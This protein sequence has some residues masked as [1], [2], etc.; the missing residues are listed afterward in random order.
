ML[1]ALQH[2]R[3]ALPIVRAF[4]MFLKAAMRNTCIVPHEYRSRNTS[5]MGAEGL[6]QKELVV[7]GDLDPAAILHHLDINNVTTIAPVH[8]GED[9]AIWR[10]EHGGATH[11]LRV[12]R[13]EQARAF[14]REVAALSA[15]AAAGLPVPAVAA[16]GEWHERPVM[17]LS[18]CAGQ[19]LLAALRER[20]WQVA[21]LGRLFGQTHARIHRITAPPA[22]AQ[23]ATA[24]ITWAGPD[25]HA[26]QQRL[27]A[28]ADSHAALLH[29][30]YHPL[31][32]MTDGRQIT[33][34]LDWTNSMAGD[35]RA[36]VARTHTILALSPIA[37]AERALPLLLFRRLLVMAWQRGYRDVA[38][39]LDDMAAFYAW[40]GAAMLR[41]LAPRAARAGHWMQ[42][43]DLEPARAWTARWRRRAGLTS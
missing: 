40:A 17:L 11:A 7:T 29:L 9:T 2:A 22:L 38:G 31:N 30:D 6:A 19:P 5:A 27:A 23:H 25:E 20:P 26:L 3:Q 4:R 13:A 33:G 24:W 43:K 12:F 37:P 18:W 15:A 1:A 34:V 16:T 8:G 39:S 36:D 41:D 10:V 35:P 42:P 32:V 28:L 14:Q 21:R